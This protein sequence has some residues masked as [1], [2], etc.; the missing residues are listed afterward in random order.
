MKVLFLSFLT[1]Y[2]AFGITFGRSTIAPRKVL[3]YLRRYGYLSSA[4]LN[5]GGVR[6]ITKIYEAVKRLQRFTGLNE[7][8][9]PRDTA[10][11]ELVSKERCSFKDI[12]KTSQFKRRRR[13]AL[14]G[15]RWSKNS[16]TYKVASYTTDLTTREVD[17]TIKAGLSMWA[18]A[19]PLTF[20]K[21]T[22]GP[23]D[24]VISFD[25]EGDRDYSF[26][27]PGGELA[28]AHFPLDN[29]A[30]SSGDIHFDDAEK[31]IV[32]SKGKGTHLLWLVLH[33]LGHSLGLEHSSDK[34]AIM[35]P[36]YPGSKSTFQLHRDDVMGIQQLYGKPAIAR[37]TPTPHVNPTQ[38]PGKL[39]PCSSTLDAMIMTADK[40]TYAFKGAFFWPVGDYGAFTDALKISQFW[41]GL[42]DDI[43][44]GYTRQF[45]GITFI[46]K[47]SRFWTFKNRIP[48]KGPS[49]LS[50]INL[51]ADVHNMDAAVE[52]GANGHL[53]IFKGNMFWRY[54]SL[55]KSI[56]PGY[57]KRIQSNLP[58]LPSNLNAALQWKNGRTYFFKDFQYYS[59][60]DTSI[61]I[62]KGYPKSI[63]TYWMGC[64]PEGL[65]MGKISPF[66]SSNGLTHFAPD[67]RVIIL[68]ATFVFARI[69]LTTPMAPGK[70]FGPLD[71]R[72]AYAIFAAIFCIVCLQNLVESSPVSSKLVAGGIDWL[73]RYGYLVNDDPR[74][75]NLRSQQ[76]LEK[77]IK[78]LQRYA[79]LKETGQMDADTIKLMGKSRCG[80]SDFGRSD[81]NKR[82]KKRFTLQGSYWQKK[83]LTYRIKS[84]TNDLSQG[85]QR[86][87]FK[88]SF[89]LWS[90]A[91]NLRIKED[92][93]LA[94]KDVD[95][96]IKFDGGHHGD[97]YP[98]DGQGG[99]LAHAFYPHNNLGLSGDA[100]FD[101]DERF[102][103]GTSNGINLD[104]VAVH[105]FG[106]SLGLEHSNVRDSIMY[107]W[108]KG[109]LPNI[110]LTND[111]TMGIQ[112]L[113]GKPS[114]QTPT[115]GVTDKPTPTEPT[116][117]VENDVCSIPY[118]D[119]FFL[120]PDGKTYAIKGTQYWIISSR[121]GLESGP[122]KVT[123]LW[124]GLPQKVDAAYKRSS[125]RLVFFSGS[126]YW[127]YFYDS[128]RRRYISEDKA[129]SITAYG[130]TMDM[131]DMDAV[132]TWGRNGRTY[133]FKGNQYWRFYGNKIDYGYPKNIR[134]W[135]GLPSKINAAMKWRNGISYF[136]AEGKY[137]RFDDI[138]IKVKDGYPRSI[139]LVWMRC[140]KDNLMVTDPIYTTSDG[141]ND[142]SIATPQAAGKG[143]PCQCSSGSTIISSSLAVLF[144]LVVFAS[145][146]NLFGADHFGYAKENRNGDNTR[147]TQQTLKGVDR[148]SVKH[149]QLIAFLD[150]T[151]VINDL[152]VKT[153]MAPGKNFDP[154]DKRTAYALC[155][156]IFCIVCLQ[157]PVE[158]SPVSSKLVAGGIDWLT[159]Y[160]Y[161]VNDDP[162]T[163]NLRSQQDLEKSIKMLQRYA[164]LKETGQMDADTIKL[165]GKSRCGVSDFGRSDNNKRRKKRFTLQGSY[166]QK[167]DLTY[168]I[169]SFTNDL[170]QGEQRQIFKK[171][172]DLW[173]KATNLRIK[174]DS[175]LADKDVDILIKF[176]G[177]HHGDAYPFDGQGGTL[178]HA[179]YPH[180]NL[181]LSG[182]AHFDDDERFTTGTSNGIN[183]DWVAVHEF[184]HS[185]GLEHSNVRDSIM[186]PWYKGYIPNIQLTNDD[187]MGIQA[188]YG[189][190]STQTPTNGV[191]DKPTPTE[192][193][194][195][196]ENDVCSIPYYD[197]FFLA[198]DGKTYAIKGTQYWIISSRTGLESGPHKV[199]DLW[200]GLPQKVDAAYKR[201]S[202]RLV[203]FSGS[204]YW[205]YFYD[206]SRR[207]YISEDKASSITAYGLTMD[208]ANMDAVFTWG[209]NG[210]T[211]FF[212]GNQYWRFYGN[213]IDYGYPKN[214]RAWKGLPGKI[215]A[216]M[217]WRN[218]ISYFF[219]EGKYYRFDD[220]AIKVKDGYPRSIALVWMR[221]EKDNLMV[222]DPTY[223]TSDGNNDASIATPQAA[224]KG[225]PCQCSSGSTIISSS[226]VVLFSLVMFAS[227]VNL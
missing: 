103:T 134:A 133:F 148:Q 165:M 174:E 37:V 8:G 78:M 137:Y 11:M 188:L 210:R 221:C 120:A 197:T 181:G 28:F 223:T 114:T 84:F 200:E 89:D 56:D 201:S 132:F 100:H 97:A 160:G 80:V 225:C 46:F 40:T 157:N 153:P 224:A 186:Y 41:G 19:T 88:K 79:G 53:Y 170:S 58:D 149:N 4:D 130:L 3:N 35:F 30:A 7:T 125:H 34:N 175:Q 140:E 189:K 122:H 124:E 145:K 131:A 161:L 173:S 138:A 66:R 135:K 218:G 194:I 70:N 48:I 220:M 127:Q 1:L 106:H 60:D 73:T 158:S 82:R 71:T 112:A 183:L 92:S 190:P 99:T 179:F 39:N 86:Q 77:S 17:D 226:L 162:R 107:P 182:D 62:R 176:D 192:P 65:A 23:A 139:A 196:V 61:R 68:M 111:D 50:E 59:L 151:G 116:I 57:P 126:R 184:G 12:G 96:L 45:D 169:K 191:T 168:R 10:T 49:N 129:S 207:R 152:K 72:T 211:Y 204:R 91:T 214:I 33:E 142:A 29:V 213:K 93:Q 115:N 102:T 26:D 54:D 43:D 222:T 108:Y 177:G 143:C 154:L 195:P 20:T 6:R 227:K 141:N 27:G 47:G 121:T 21:V 95:I 203:F 52:W 212:K 113:Y 166:W 117:P 87:I 171:S 69:L 9:N 22:N 150:F 217:K 163:G 193:T 202:H 172:F 14:H 105:E 187:T 13:Y 110:Q 206:S 75:G 2:A 159:R 5:L 104:W 24:I 147:S 18:K 55:R 198:P 64:S 199:T 128:S 164:G 109:Y 44:A 180:N 119:T 178:A 215:N 90:K 32:K 25:K 136:F 101:D 85:E 216:A 185:L 205:Q 167:K 15:T 74:T 209:R 208:M 98:F 42:E 16:L 118:Y 36:L 155:A 83:D 94:D 67:K 31:F 146:V 219:A 51:P 38:F 63:T 156:A 76:D 144:S 123:D 81:N